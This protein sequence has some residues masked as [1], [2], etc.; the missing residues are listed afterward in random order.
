MMLLYL[1]TSVSPSARFSPP[2]SGADGVS[3]SVIGKIAEQR[4]SSG[5]CVIPTG[6]EPV[7]SEPESDI[8]SIELRDRL[9]GTKMMHFFEFH[10]PGVG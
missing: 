8:L 3:R 4:E 10:K 9:E 2:R 6:I 5:Y 7:P 1:I